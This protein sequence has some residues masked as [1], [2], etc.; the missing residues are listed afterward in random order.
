VL[1]LFVSAGLFGGRVLVRIDPAKPSDAIYVL[2]G[3]HLERAVE[4]ADLFRAGFSNRILISRGRME[5]AEAVLLAEGVRVP[6]EADVARGVLIE[7]LG[8]P[9]G[10]VEALRTSVASTADEANAIVA[11]ARA[12]HWT[13]LIIITD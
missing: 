8:L 5:P 2:G 13:R 9:A 10:H 12:E 3:A 7:Q 6:S 11:R 4:A 1:T